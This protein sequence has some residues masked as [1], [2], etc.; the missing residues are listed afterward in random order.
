VRRFLDLFEAGD[1]VAW[2][3]HFDAGVV[4]DTSASSLPLAGV[5]RGHEGVERFFV[6][7]LSTW[8]D[9]RIAHS[10]LIDA[11]DAVVVVFRQWGTGRAS[12]V[13]AERDFFGVYELVDRRVVRY[14][15]FDTREEAMGAAGLAG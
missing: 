10:E 5:Y 13:S 3:D 1:R 12:G 11:D 6:D 8:D 4:W 9:Y 2:R 7:W 14:R 15:L